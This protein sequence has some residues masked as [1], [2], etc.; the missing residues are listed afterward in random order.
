[1]SVFLSSI[2]NVIV[3]FLSPVQIILLQ[4][5]LGIL[6][7]SIFIEELIKI[8]YSNDIEQKIE[9]VVKNRNENVILNDNSSNDKKYFDKSVT[10]DFL[11]EI[12]RVVN[13]LY[14]KIHSDSYNSNIYINSNLYG[15]EEL[16]LL[17]F[18]VVGAG[19]SY[20]PRDGGNF[21]RTVLSQTKIL[22][23]C[24]KIL[25][26]NDEKKIAFMAK[27]VQERELKLAKL[28]SLN[29]NE[30]ESSGVD[31]KE[32][33]N[34]SNNKNDIIDHNEKNENPYQVTG[35][36]KEKVVY[37]EVGKA[38]EKVGKAKEKEKLRSIY[39]DKENNHMKDIKDGKKIKTR[40]SPI[41]ERTD[42]YDS[43]DIE[44]NQITVRSIIGL[45][46]VFI[47]FPSL[48]SFI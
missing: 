31:Y 15:C 37:E 19:V 42:D 32:Y 27:K 2:N 23:I 8:E 46:L 34:D 35:N 26:S 36:E 38:K 11:I 20:P 21:L 48:I 28:A 40:H 43:S 47:F 24:C 39:N 44:R 14:E 29:I 25:K 6:E 3:E 30:V 22:D 33:T 13:I 18:N 41:I 45:C 9:A 17:C 7:D 16:L 1:M 12:I 10:K 5:I 4:I